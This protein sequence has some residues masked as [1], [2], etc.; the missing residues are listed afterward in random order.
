MPGTVVISIA[1]ATLTACGGGGGDS[2]PT[3]FTTAEGVYSGTISN[4]TTVSSFSTVVLDDGTFWTMYG[5]SVGNTFYVS[6]ISQG[7]GT[8]GNGTFTSS[9]IRDFITDPPFAG[10]LTASYVAGAS[11]TGSFS[12]ASG[13]V[14]FSGTA[15]PAAQFNYNTPALSSNVVGNWTLTSISTNLISMNIAANGSYTAV[16]NGG[17]TVSGTIVPRASGKNIFDLRMLFGPAPC[18]L[19][20]LTGDG[21]GIYS[22]LANGTQQLILNAVDTSRTYGSAAFGTRQ[23]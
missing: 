7:K 3:P 9:N 2:L 11:L 5:Y 10:T 17:C 19:P 14:G 23:I 21:I 20:G 22:T 4:S 12:S 1:L 8:S 18:S 15:V 13:N 16:E 6:G